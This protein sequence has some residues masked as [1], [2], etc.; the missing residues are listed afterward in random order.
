V[1]EAWSVET[2][3]VGE[4]PVEGAT[5]RPSLAC[6][7]LAHNA[8]AELPRYLASVERFADV[9]VA[10]DAA[11][12]DETR[13]VLAEHPLAKIV[14][15][16][17]G[18]RDERDLRDRLLIAARELDPDWIISVDADES[19][20]LEDAMALRE[21]VDRRPSRDHAYGFTVYR[22]TADDGHYDRVGP[23]VVRMFPCRDNQHF[24]DR[25][26]RG[27]MVPVDLPA[28]NW[29][30]TTIRLQHHPS[31]RADEDSRGGVALEP[32]PYDYPPG[33]DRQVPYRPPR[34]PIGV[35][36]LP[37]RRSCR[38]FVPCADPDASSP[39]ADSTAEGLPVLSAIVISQNDEARI[40]RCV[41]SVVE[42]SCSEPF[43]VIVV[44]SGSDRTAD[45][46]REQFPGVT[47]VELPR[48]A[49]PGEARNAGLR[50]AH[51]EYISFPGS[52]VELPP[53]SLEARIRAHDLGFSMVTGAIVNGLESNVGWAS[54]FLDHFLS[55][56]GHPSGQLA[57]A[58]SHCSYTHEAL[59][60][61]GGFPED[62]RTGEDTVV[63]KRLFL[64]GHAAYRSS[65][66]AL[67]HRSPCESAGQL[68]KHHFKRGV[69]Y[70]AIL[71]EEIRRGEQPVDRALIRWL[72]VGYV[73]VRLRSIDANV[74][75]YGIDLLAEYDRA[76]PLILLGAT[77]AWAGIWSELIR[78]SR[79]RFRG[80]LRQLQ[81]AFRE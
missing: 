5:I 12:T 65:K 25:G 68:W 37:P 9:L 43:E 10:L 64:L 73:P 22:M 31:G 27:A 2:V 17:R 61:V 4:G 58:P 54:Y 14:L 35:R 55:L 6:L 77:A 81:R 49:L 34:S 70:G 18:Y 60:E 26:L 46:V 1:S 59:L 23:W 16:G 3:P 47:L 21:F 42:Q 80:V 33:D 67:I 48:P 39:V 50:V 13:S 7:L 40:E 74:K 41:R 29:I 62:R 71:V 57:Y 63:N 72:T 45:I 79:D 11:S 56:P 20:S 30:R 52:H 69:G 76:S 36:V 24:R 75:S 28:T 66:L 44:T 38:Q 19:F 32:Y 51:G 78:S 8:V 15:D 53:G